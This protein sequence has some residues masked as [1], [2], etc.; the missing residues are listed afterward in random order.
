MSE[1]LS[2]CKALAAMVARDDGK[3]NVDEVVFVAHAALELG[4]DAAENEEVQKVLV[5]GGDFEALLADVETDE[6]RLFLFRRIVSA[7]LLDSSI[8]EAEKRFISKTAQSFG[9]NMRVVDEYISW[10]CE[11]LDW[12]RRGLAVMA[13][14]KAK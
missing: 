3:P 12:E 11:G 9:Y 5:E 1:Q 8:N 14:L 4:L 7:T 2:A 10:L 6:S 13:R